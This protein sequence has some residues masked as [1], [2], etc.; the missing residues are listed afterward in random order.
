MIS[1]L[2]NMRRW[3]LGEFRDNIPFLMSSD[4]QNRIFNSRLQ[5]V[6]LRCSI[7]Y[8]LPKEKVHPCDVR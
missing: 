8:I 6:Y 3:W 7:F 5:C 2:P 4:G 1:A